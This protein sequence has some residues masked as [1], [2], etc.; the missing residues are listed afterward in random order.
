MGNIKSELQTIKARRPGCFQNLKCVLTAVLHFRTSQINAVVNGFS[1]YDSTKDD[2]IESI[3]RD[4]IDYDGRITVVDYFNPRES[5]SNAVVV[6]RTNMYGNYDEP[7]FRNCVIY[8][9]DKDRLVD[10][11]LVD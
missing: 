9:V 1:V 5:V 3:I 2:V 11:V 6:M 10:R 8:I 7:E 4:F